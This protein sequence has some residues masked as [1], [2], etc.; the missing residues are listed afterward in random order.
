MASP[1]TYYKVSSLEEPYT[2]S[3]S[4]QGDIR[5]QRGLTAASGVNLQGGG[6]GKAQPPVLSLGAN[7]D[8]VV[9]PSEVL[10]QPLPPASSL[11]PGI[12]A[13]VALDR[14]L[15]IQVSATDPE[16]DPLSARWRCT[17]GS[18]SLPSPRPMTWN[19]HSQRWETRVEWRPPSTATVGQVFELN[20]DVQD[21][22]G[23]SITVGGNVV[24]AL[25]V[26]T[27]PSGKLVADYRYGTVI[28]I[29]SP[30][31][32]GMREIN[33]PDTVCMLSGTPDGERL[34][35]AFWSG[36]AFAGTIGASNLDGTNLR[37]LADLRGT[38]GSLCDPSVAPSG[39]IAAWSSGGVVV[40]NGD[41]TNP[42]TI[43]SGGD[44]YCPRWSPD[45]TKVLYSQADYEIFRV[46]ADGSNQVDLGPGTAPTWSP[47]GTRVLFRRSDGTYLMNQDGTGVQKISNDS[48]PNSGDCLAWSPDGSQVAWVNNND[49]VVANAD[50]SSPKVVAT[51]PQLNHVQWLR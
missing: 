22:R 45:A 23:G 14:F 42:Q 12:K 41:G 49:V 8:P 36:A 40:M 6:D 44:H 3:V 18:F 39:R 38:I 21:D 47:D 43:T 5:V 1:L 50:G 17:G 31:G 34:L 2:I 29:F 46:D 11:P 24:S 27:A 25:K 48:S 15:T 19:P 10:V 33:L 13:L 16:G 37:I 20:C 28:S 35:F 9:D 26:Q 30:D 51:F 7:G 4:L 32:S